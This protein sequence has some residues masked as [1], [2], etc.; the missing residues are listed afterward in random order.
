MRNDFFGARITV[1]GLVTG[2]DIARQLSGLDLGDRVLIPS[3]MLRRGERVFLDDMT[4]DELA[5][6]LGVP[7]EPVDCT[8]EA[9]VRAVFGEAPDETAKK[10]STYEMSRLPDGARGVKINAKTDRS[11]RRQAQ[12][13]Q[14]PAF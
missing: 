10:P 8:G 9:L 4:V 2:R 5:G 7:V 6:A 3:V 1:A 14:K 13:G 11:H 12:R